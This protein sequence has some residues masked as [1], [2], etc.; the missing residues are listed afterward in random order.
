M[1]LLPIPLFRSAVFSLEPA[2]VVPPSPTPANVEP[3]A[4]TAK[5]LPAEPVT[6]ISAQPATSLASPAASPAHSEPA[7]RWNVAALALLG[8]AALLA[9]GT[10]L[11]YVRRRRAST[12]RPAWSPEQ[13]GTLLPEDDA[14]VEEATL[15]SSSS[16]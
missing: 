9:S 1:G 16:R 11:W 14:A 4:P 2:P 6:A 12:D 3:A 13:D 8:V 5:V 10:W 7:N 15:L